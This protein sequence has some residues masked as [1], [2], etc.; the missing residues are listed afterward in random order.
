MES[1]QRVRGTWLIMNS[2]EHAASR[3][4]PLE[5]LSVVLLKAGA[6]DAARKTVRRQIT[7]AS[8]QRGYERPTRGDRPQAFNREHL[9]MRAQM[10]G[11]ECPDIRRVFR[12]HRQ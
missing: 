4:Q 12:E 2:D 8:L 6:P 11:N 1:R 10:R 3:R 5:N 7:I 9:R